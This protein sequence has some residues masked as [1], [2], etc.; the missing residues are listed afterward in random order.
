MNINFH[1][2]AV[3][4]VALEAG[5]SENEAQRISMFS[6]FVDDFADDSV[7]IVKTIPP[8]AQHLAKKMGGYWLFTPVRTGFNGVL[9]YVDFLSYQSRMD[10]TMPFHF[11]PSEPWAQIN[12]NARENYRVKPAV[13][14]DGSLISEFL[15]TAQDAI[16]SEKEARD[17]SLM[18]IGMLLHTFADTYAHQNFS[19]DWGWENHAKL[20]QVINN[21]DDDDLTECF[22]GWAKDLPDANGEHDLEFSLLPSIGHANV[23]TA[24][25]DSYITFSMSQR[26]KKGDG[27]NLKTKERNNTILFCEAAKEMLRFLLCCNGQG[28]LDENKWASFEK[29]LRGGLLSSGR[30]HDLLSRHWMGCFEGHS[31][32]EPCFF[33]NYNKKDVLENINSPTLQTV[34]D[35][36]AGAADNELLL[37]L[38]V[39]HD[40]S[41]IVYKNLSESY[42]R[43]SVEAY[44]IRDAAMNGGYV[45]NC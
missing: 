8:W 19:G 25:D 15:Y 41:P 40:I 2:F 22:T 39:K 32:I 7:K 18:R 20:E 27:Y 6:Q 31:F 36:A 17:V 16:L 1:Y 37:N 44:K 5:F 29:C 21:T 13:L 26:V 42:L 34:V 11:I 12:K 45:I 30:N 28:P 38:A 9:D 23:I 3:K 33:F 24:P 14:G 4:A 10:I 35:D 43:Y